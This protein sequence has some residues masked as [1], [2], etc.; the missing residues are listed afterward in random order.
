MQK[1]ILKIL[2]IKILL[3]KFKKEE[4]EK[5]TLLCVKT[6]EKVIRFYTVFKTKL[7]YVKN[8]HIF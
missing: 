5:K 6:I 1:K 3:Y 2:Y 4:E 8:A 7:K